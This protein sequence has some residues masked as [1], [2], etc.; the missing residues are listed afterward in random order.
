MT[1]S[2]TNKQIRDLVAQFVEQVGADSIVVI[3]S[4]VG[5]DL[6]SSKCV[7]FGNQFACR[8]M[9]KTMHDDYVLAEINGRDSNKKKTKE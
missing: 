8:A 7:T 5:K 2:N 3:W 4:E 9:V 1:N 6:T